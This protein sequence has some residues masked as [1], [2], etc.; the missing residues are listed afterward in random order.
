MIHHTIRVKTIDL[1]EDWQKINKCPITIRSEISQTFCY[2]N[3]SRYLNN[4]LEIF[5][6]ESDSSLI[7]P[8]SLFESFEAF[9]QLKNFKQS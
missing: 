4:F 9:L 6:Y 8:S 5:K 3:Q 2:L 7:T 1:N